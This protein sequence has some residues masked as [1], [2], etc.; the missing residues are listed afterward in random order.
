MAIGL[1]V[2]NANASQRQPEAAIAVN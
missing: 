1:N 2:E